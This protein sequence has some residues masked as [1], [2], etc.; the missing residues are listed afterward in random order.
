MKKKS[1]TTSAFLRIRVLF[2]LILCLG[3]GLLGFAALAAPA[4]VS[5]S[6]DQAPA[7]SAVDSPSTARAKPRET[8]LVKTGRP[9]K[10]DLRTLPRVKPV[11]RERPEL[12]EPEIAPKMYVPPGGLTNN[13]QAAIAPFAPA[14]NAPAPP[15][16]NIFE[17]LDRFNWGA[18]S[19]P[20]TNG[21]VGPTYYIQTVNTSIGIFRKSDGFQEA[22]FTFNTFMSQ[23]N[24][25]NLCDTNNFGDPVV[26]YDTFEDRWIIS[27]FAFLTDVGGNV[28]APA[29]QC[30]AASMTGDPVAGGWNFYSIQV[31]DALGDYPKLGIW[32]DG[33]Y[34]SA[35]M[36]TFGAGSSFVTARAWAFNKAQ[37]YAGSPTVKVVSFNLPG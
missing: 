17:G 31:S 24:F 23:G 22:A 34:M 37:M 2:T 19:P 11:E 35:N 20:D 6:I 14:I 10:G 28:L 27:D 16:L 36:F 9:F 15:P 5:S 21:D 32:P 29:F 30:F 26:L 12:E 1:S 18:G 13:S 4:D 8:R 3:A 25:G 7:A 33:L